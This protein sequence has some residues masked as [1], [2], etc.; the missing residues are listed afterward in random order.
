MRL[1]QKIT[2]QYNVYIEVH[3]Q[4]VLYIYTLYPCVTI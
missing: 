2:I 4:Y 1:D 3:I